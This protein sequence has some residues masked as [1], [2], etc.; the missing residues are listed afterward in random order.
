MSAQM[1][2]VYLLRVGTML[3]RERDAGS[4]IKLSRQL[5][6]GIPPPIPTVLSWVKA[7][8]LWQV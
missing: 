6:V 7:D 3:R 8:I 1:M 5:T 4:T 2:E